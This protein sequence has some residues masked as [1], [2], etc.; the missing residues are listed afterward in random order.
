MDTKAIQTFLNRRTIRKYK[1][2]PIEKEVLNSLLDCGI[3][4]SNCGN[5]QNYSII[6][7]QDEDRRK[8][9]AAL[10][11]NQPMALQAPI[12]LT[13]CCDLNRFQLWCQQRGAQKA[14]DN[15]LWLNVG[16]IDA[17]ATAQSIANAA[18]AL[19]LGICYLGS[20]TYMAPEIAKFLCLPKYVVPVATLT[21]GYPDENPPLT[22][23][24]PMNAVVHYEQYHNPSEQEINQMYNEIEQNIQNKEF[25]QINNQENLAKVFVNCRYTHKDNIDISRKYFE[26]IKEQGFFNQ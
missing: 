14:Y 2:K 3:R 8:Q 10:N 5:M 17:T 4:A 12:I 22:E 1:N 7:T 26:F 21:V 11:L 24:L 23:R 19:G 13:I 18:E 20:V 16:T 15:F 9:L 25:C 6:V